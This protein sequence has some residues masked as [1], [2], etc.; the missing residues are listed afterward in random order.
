MDSSLQTYIL[1]EVR[2]EGIANYSRSL[3][4]LADVVLNDRNPTEIER[5]ISIYSELMTYQ[6]APINNL[7]YERRRMMEQL[8]G[9]TFTR[10]IHVIRRRHADQ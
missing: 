1:T 10:P 3:I 4:E 6:G 9:I 8:S 7:R 5:F 2:R